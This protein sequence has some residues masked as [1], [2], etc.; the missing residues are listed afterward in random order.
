MTYELTEEEKKKV[1]ASYYET[2]QGGPRGTPN[3][4]PWKFTL[5]LE[6]QALLDKQRKATK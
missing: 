6:G 1:I 5:T 3:K 4:E 2:V